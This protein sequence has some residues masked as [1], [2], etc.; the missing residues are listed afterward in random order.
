MENNNIEE[1]QVTKQKKEIKYARKIF[2]ILFLV[3]ALFILYLVLNEPMCPKDLILDDGYCVYRFSQK[4]QLQYKCKSGEINGINKCHIPKELVYEYTKDSAEYNETDYQKFVNECNDKKG[5]I[6]EE[7]VGSICKYEE[8][9]IPDGK[10]YCGEDSK[11]KGD[12]CVYE[13]K[14]Q[15]AQ[16]RLDNLKKYYGLE[17]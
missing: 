4:A 17:K 2:G 1:I 12:M 11:L 7:S 5:T 9:Y 3:S 13:E 6:K 15:E 8:T 16:T 14:V 10:L